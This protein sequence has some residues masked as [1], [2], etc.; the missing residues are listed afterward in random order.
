MSLKKMTLCALLVALSFILANVRIMGSIAFDSLPAFVGGLAIGGVYGAV[1]GA[2]GHLLTATLSGFPYSIPVHLITAV[3]MAFTVY[4]YTV[5]YELIIKSG[6]K[7]VAVICASIVGA[8]LNGPLA[9]FALQSFLIPMMGEA[10]LFPFAVTL[11]A[12]ALANIALAFV[13]YFMLE[14]VKIAEKL[15]NLQ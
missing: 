13:L 10:A 1:I 11:A 4:F 6:S 2:L 8:A 7:V 12:A 15:K 14:K 9:V 5:A 3:I